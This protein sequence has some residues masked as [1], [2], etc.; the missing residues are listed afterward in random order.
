MNG[1]SLQS[2]S[3][4]GADIGAIDLVLA[5]RTFV[6]DIEFFES[7]LS[8]PD[9]VSKLLEGL[10]GKVL[11]SV[12]SGAWR[13]SGSLHSEAGVLVEKHREPVCIWAAIEHILTTQS[14]TGSMSAYRFEYGNNASSCD[15]PISS[16]YPSLESIVSLKVR[17]TMNELNSSFPILLVNVK[18]GTS[19]Y[20]VDSPSRFVRVGGSSIGSSTVN[21]L[22]KHLTGADSILGSAELARKLDN[23]SAADL[24][25][26]DIYGGDCESIGL[27]GNIIASCF[28]KANVGEVDSQDI[29]KSLL[30]LISINTAQ[31]ANLHASLNG[32]RTAVIV[33]S[34][35]DCPEVSECIQRVLMILSK[36]KDTLKAIFFDKSRYLGCLGAL[37]RREKLVS[38]LSEKYRDLPVNTVTME[39]GV[40]DETYTHLR[41]TTPPVVNRF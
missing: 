39:E 3:S 24:L 14:E 29:A 10:S 34:I 18:T 28:G 19:F 1:T 12:G 22:L 26:S 33:G 41:V 11:P 20:R 32:C 35:G 25:V 5:V 36:N 15:H 13:L 38:G 37:L 7:P 31:L 2:F 8:D 9:R 17:V 21:A 40:D 16:P 4:V 30:D 27:P 6:G 23:P